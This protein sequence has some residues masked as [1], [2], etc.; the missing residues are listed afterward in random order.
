MPAAVFLVVA[1]IKTYIASYHFPNPRIVYILRND[2]HFNNSCRQQTAMSRGNSVPSMRQEPQLLLTA[3]AFGG[4]PLVTYAAYLKNTT[5]EP[6]TA[7]YT[8]NAPTVK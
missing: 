8:I 7:V 4:N 1:A 6:T 2:L 3:C 5:S